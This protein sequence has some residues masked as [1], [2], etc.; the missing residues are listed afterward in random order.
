MFCEY[1]Q[2][3]RI[4]I[5]GKDAIPTNNS[6]SKTDLSEVFGFGKGIRFIAL[7]KAFKT[8]NKLILRCFLNSNLHRW[9][10]PK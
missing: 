9:I 10:I 4:K 3:Q 1:M 2:T 7:F 8:Y 6:S 5:L